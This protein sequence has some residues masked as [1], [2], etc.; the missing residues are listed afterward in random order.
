MHSAEI[1]F[2]LPTTRVNSASLAESEID[3]VDVYDNAYGDDFGKAERRAGKQSQHDDRDERR[4]RIDEQEQERQ[5]NKSVAR[6]NKDA[7]R[8][9]TSRHGASEEDKDL[10]RDQNAER[11][12]DVGKDD[13]RIAGEKGEPDGRPSEGTEKQ[14][15]RGRRRKI[16]EWKGTTEGGKAVYKTESELTPGV[17]YFQLVAVDTDGKQS[18]PSAPFRV[19]I[20]EE[21]DTDRPEK[22]DEP[23]QANNVWSTGTEEDRPSLITQVEVRLV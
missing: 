3:H 14:A 15:G 17:H 1:T 6:D 4:A 7:S 9:D 20:S 13:N 21:G 5:K 8:R 22:S 2:K 10:H 11:D 23:A 18:D 16:G 12:A 19:N